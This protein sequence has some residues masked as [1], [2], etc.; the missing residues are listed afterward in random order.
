MCSTID[1]SERENVLETLE[2]MCS[3][4]HDS[5]KKKEVFSCFLNL[6]HEFAHL[7]QPF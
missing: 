3:N 7:S 4:C 5:R 2:S 1:V 6:K